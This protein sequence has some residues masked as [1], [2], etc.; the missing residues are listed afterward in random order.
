M[1]SRLEE[2]KR[3]FQGL[4]TEDVGQKR[5]QMNQVFERVLEEVY[6][7]SGRDLPEP[8]SR[9]SELEGFQGYIYKLSQEFLTS[10]STLEKERK[11]EKMLEH[12]E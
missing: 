8:G 9:I 6:R 12:L 2:A 3:I 1:S 7:R 11:L 10:S 4:E 5:Y